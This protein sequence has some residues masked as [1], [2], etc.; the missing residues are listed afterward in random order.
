[1]KALENAMRAVELQPGDGDRAID[2]MRNA[3]A[4]IV[5]TESTD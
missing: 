3:G 1:V 2:E 5:S 4:E